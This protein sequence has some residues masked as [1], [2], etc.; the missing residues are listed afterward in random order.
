MNEKSQDRG[1]G[2]IERENGYSTICDE[3]CALSLIFNACSWFVSMEK[4]HSN[5]LGGGINIPDC[6]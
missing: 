3:H 2:K 5:G 4:G 6:S 1:K